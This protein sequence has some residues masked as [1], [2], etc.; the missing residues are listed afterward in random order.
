MLE[1]VGGRAGTSLGGGY[2]E[3]VLAGHGSKKA[4]GIP[5]QGQHI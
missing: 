1:G 5:G 3:L 2:M 4:Q